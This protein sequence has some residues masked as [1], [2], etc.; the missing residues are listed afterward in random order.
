MTKKAADERPAEKILFPTEEVKLSSGERVQVRE[1]N[2][3]TWRLMIPRVQALFGS[4]MAIA[5]GEDLL[6]L[7]VDGYDEVLA[8]VADTLGWKP[9]Q[10]VAQL[11]FGDLLA[12]LQVIVEQNLLGGEDGGNLGK[13]QA[14]MVNL[15]KLGSASVESPAAAS[16]APSS[17]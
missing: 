8:M 10:L 4:F 14:L 17:S 15:D 13:V 11:R 1:W 9:D 3:E 2:L 6:H 16:P 12:L 5:Q 7:L